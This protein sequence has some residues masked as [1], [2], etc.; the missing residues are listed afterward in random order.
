MSVF[1]RKLK[2][3][4]ELSPNAQLREDGRK[5]AESAE[6]T[7][8]ALPRI[9]RREDNPIE[10]LRRYVE[11]LGSELELVAVLGKRVKLL[12]ARGEAP[13]MKAV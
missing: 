8:S 1:E 10:A 4:C 5:I 11:V 12:G 3:N 2:T 13:G 6:L 7:Q 9:E